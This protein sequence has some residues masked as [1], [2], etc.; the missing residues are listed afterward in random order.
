DRVTGLLAGH[1]FLALVIAAV[2]NNLDG[3]GSNRYTRLPGH[4]G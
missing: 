2:G 3:L 4:V 1:D